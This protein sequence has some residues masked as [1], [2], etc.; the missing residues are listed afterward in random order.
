MRF[1]T[2]LGSGMSGVF[3]RIIDDGEPGRLESISQFAMQRFGDG[4]D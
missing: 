3:V 1:P 4:H 2:G